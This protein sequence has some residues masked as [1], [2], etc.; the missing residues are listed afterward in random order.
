MLEFTE[1][2]NCRWLY[3]TEDSFAKDDKFSCLAIFDAD[4]VADFNI[5]EAK[6]S[7]SDRT[8][9][10]LVLVQKYEPIIEWKKVDNPKLQRLFDS[11][12]KDKI[13]DLRHLVLQKGHEVTV[14]LTEKKRVDLYWNCKK[15]SST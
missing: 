15:I 10:D 5:I 14:V 8:K 2:F 12:I 9:L 11:L 4:G 7:K 3:D 1:G 6:E 13:V